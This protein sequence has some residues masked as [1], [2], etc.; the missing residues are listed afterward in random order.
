[1]FVVSLKKITIKQKCF[2]TNRK[3]PRPGVVLEYACAV[4][5]PTCQKHACAVIILTYPHEVF[6]FRIEKKDVYTNL[7]LHPG[8]P[9]DVVSRP[10]LQPPHTGHGEQHLR[11]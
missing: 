7:W 2:V 4:V 11:F 8:I 6:T 3:M 5:L 1:M 10:Q 9:P